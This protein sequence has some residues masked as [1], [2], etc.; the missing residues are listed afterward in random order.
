MKYDRDETF[1]REKLTA[2]LHP[3]AVDVWPAVAEQLPAAHKMRR[4]RWL[5]LAV[6]VATPL[7]IAA[8]VLV[9]TAE[10]TN[11]RENPRPSFAPQANTGYAITYERQ[12]FTLDSDLLAGMIANHNGET[13]ADGTKPGSINLSGRLH[14][15]SA[16]GRNI[17]A[18][19][20]SAAG[21]SAE[22]VATDTV[23]AA[24]VIPI[25]RG[26]VPDKVYLRM[27]K[28]IDGCRVE[29][30]AVAYLGDNSKETAAAVF[31]KDRAWLTWTC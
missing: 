21:D 17:Y 16:D 4:I 3:T 31:E 7:L 18:K 1:L 20:A 8:G 23:Y 29:M 6:C 13:A 15:D 5:R 30:M 26:A 14:P 24:A 22:F 12:Y 10:F 9:G 28:Q 11:L 19:A 2:G 27:G 25:G